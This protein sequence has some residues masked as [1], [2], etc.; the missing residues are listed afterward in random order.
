MAGA[1]ALRDAERCLQRAQL[2]SDVAALDRL[3]D[4]RLVFTGPDGRQALHQ[5]GRSARPRIRRAGDDAR[6]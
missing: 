3:I 1:E 4:D 6:R 5:A 2:A